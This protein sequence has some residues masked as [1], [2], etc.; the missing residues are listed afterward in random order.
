LPAWRAAK[1]RHFASEPELEQGYR[2]L[3]GYLMPEEIPGLAGP[4]L[5]D[6]LA[7]ARTALAAAERQV[8]ASRGGETPHASVARLETRLFL[9]SQLLRDVDA[10]SMA[11]GLEVRVPLVD[12]VLQAAVWPALGRH[13]DLL[14]RKQLLHGTLARPLPEEVVG[15]PKRGFTL[16]FD[17]WM[18]GQLGG[19]VRA[20]LDALA[21]RGWL[22]AAAPGRI[23]AA[24]GAGQA[25][26]SRAWGLGLLGRFLE[27][28]P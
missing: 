24:W 13:P 6:T 12:H 10:V 20:G 19:Q 15:A 2:A 28:A 18:R 1:W 21:A 14:K 25:H 22:H 27:D 7:A 3:R 16:P 23:W 17:R 26:W 8:F 4:A 5:L 11:H 9:G